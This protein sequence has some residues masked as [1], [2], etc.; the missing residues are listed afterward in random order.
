M[1]IEVIFPVYNEADTLS[2]QIKKFIDYFDINYRKNLIITIA[3]NGSTDLTP[4][5]CESLLKNKL[6]DNYLFISEKGRGRAIKQ[7]IVS[8]KADIVSY[9]DIDLSTDLSHFKPLVDSI[10]SDRNDISIGSRLSKKSKVIGRKKIREFTSRAYNLLIKIYFPKSKIDDMQCGFKAFSREKIL[11]ILNLVENNKWFF[12]TELILLARKYNF[13]IDQI[14]VKWTD[15]PNTS[16]NIIS[17]AI[18]DIVGLTK[19][20][21]KLFKKIYTEHD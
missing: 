10:A 12:D 11:K 7:S 1:K 13:K 6:I 17:T 8:S 14:P 9:M 19:L 20:R 3:D 16:V 4:K 5:I 21:L 2:N 15:D 18:E